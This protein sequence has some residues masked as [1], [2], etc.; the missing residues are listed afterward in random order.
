MYSTQ[1]HDSYNSE[2]DRQLIGILARGGRAQAGA[3]VH[4]VRPAPAPINP[5]IRPAS[6]IIVV[7]KPHTNPGRVAITVR[8][9]ARFRGSGTLDRI[10]VATSG[11][12]HIFRTRTAANEMQFNGTDN[13]FNGLDLSRGV[14]LF[15]T[16]DRPSGAAN[17]FQLRLT[18]TPGPN[19]GAPVT[20]SLT[21]VELTLDVGLSR[22]SAGVAP[23]IMSAND[24]INVGRFVQVRN[25]GF[26]H[27]RAMIVLRPPNPQ[28]ALTVRL[29]SITN[30]LQVFGFETPDAGQGAHPRP[31]S[32]TSDML[33][34]NPFELF[35]EATAPSTGVRDTGFRYGVEGVENEADRVAMTAVQFDV[36][37]TANNAVAATT[38]VRFGL[39]DRAFDPATG[40]LLN[41]AANANHFIGADARHF[42][43]R[44]RD[45]NAGATPQMEWRT[46]NAD[47]TPDHAPGAQPLP[48]VET[49]LNSHR[50]FSRP[51]FL[52]T[53]DNDR[54]LTNS[55]LNAAAVALLLPRI[56]KVTVDNTHQLDGRLTA[57][58][59]PSPGQTMRTAAGLLSRTPEE[60]RR[61]R[62]H[63]VN[64]RATAG[65]TG[66]LPAA[67][68]T[69][70][71]NL[72]HSIY[73][74]CGIFAEVNEIQIDPP[75]S[76]LAWPTL[77]P[78]PVN[79]AFLAGPVVEGF[80]FTAPNL[81]PSTTQSDIITAV[82]NQLGVGFDPNDIFIVFTNRVL[83]APVPPPPV[84]VPPNPPP[85][86]NFT[87][88]GGEA[89]PDSWTTTAG[90]TARGFGFV[91]VL[92][93]NNLAEI[94]EATHITTDLNN[95]AGGHF[96]LGLPDPA[97]GPGNVDG[98]NLMHRHFLISNGDV[99]D[100]KRL[101]NRRFTDANYVPTL[102]LAPQI[103]GIRR[104]GARFIRNF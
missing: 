65:G 69:S 12:I 103:D 87:T 31:A 81:I 46:V 73:A 7:K 92:D 77:Y 3:V 4:R 91:S 89:F 52:V 51:L 66:V 53:D 19:V 15:A 54:Q 85:M 11:G 35:V 56:R 5:I 99:K 97:P 96:D 30:Q 64:V 14:E 40:N 68:L 83:S 21:A 6:T 48:L 72:F 28:I 49:A 95:N 71:I 98:R 8:T 26:D 67:R 17:D 70:A 27:E 75:A 74:V 41:G 80:T 94:H 42:F 37:N 58:Y 20:V 86:V 2:A 10:T 34:P 25:P 61:L 39:W 38:F 90:A 50:H 32:F 18:L 47:G 13:V 29:E 101:W 9:S 78:H 22:P 93:T 104:A 23:P 33:T 16:A 63:L 76:C 55:G 57:T 62:V 88:G 79:V 102:V 43:F 82:R 100:S 60:R 36:T 24:K 45:R 1:R 59:T 84:V 44:L